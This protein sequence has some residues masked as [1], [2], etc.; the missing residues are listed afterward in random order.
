MQMKLFT[1]GNMTQ[2]QWM[3]PEKS[4]PGM[5]DPNCIAFAYRS[6]VDF[7]KVKLLVSKIEF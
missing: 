6:A 2:Y 1:A 3:I 7:V 4:G 5:S